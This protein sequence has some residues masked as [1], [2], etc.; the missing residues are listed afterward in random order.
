MRSC[1][2]RDVAPRALK[3]RPRGGAAFCLAL[4]FGLALILA[5][6]TLTFKGPLPSADAVLTTQYLHA[7]DV[8]VGGATYNTINTGAVTGTL[9]ESKASLGVASVDVALADTSG[10]TIF[11]SNPVPAGK[12]WNLSGV[13]TFDTAVKASVSTRL[14]MRAKVYRINVNGGISQLAY[15]QDGTRRDVT[16]SYQVFTWS[17]TMPTGTNINAGERFGVEF[18][19]YPNSVATGQFAYLGFD[20]ST[21]RSDVGAQVTESSAPANVRQAHVRVGKDTPLSAM[22]WYGA[23][24][25]TGIIYQS[26]NFRIR[27]Q[28]YNDGTTSSSW[29][30]RLDWSSTSGSGYA[31]VPLTSG[32]TPFFISNTTQFAN[33]DP[34]S[35]VDFALGVGAGTAQAGV[36][37]DT[38]NP[39]ASA[40]TLNTGSYTEIEFSVQ[41]NTNAGVGYIYYF[42]LS[43][44]GTPLDA[45]DI[46][47]GVVKISSPPPPSPTP[48]NPAHNSSQPYSAETAACAACH[49]PHTST[50][51]TSL[52]KTWPEEAICFTCHD[53]SGGPNIQAQFNKPYKMPLAATTGIHSL[54]EWRT[55]SP[56]SF[57]GSN[58]H[59][60]CVDC[61][62]P[63]YAAAGNHVLGQNYATG[64]LQRMWG[65]TVNNINPWASPTYDTTNSVTYQYQICFKCHTTWAYGSNPPNTPSGGFPETDISKEFNPL[66]PSYMPVEDIGNNPFRTAGGV[67]Y[68]S[69][70]IGGFTPTS[71]L[72]CSDCHASDNDADPRGPHGSNNPFILRGPWNRQTGQRTDAKVPGINSSGHLCF[73]CHDFQ[74]YTNQN[75]VG[76]PNQTGFSGGGKNMHALMVGAANKSYSNAA[77]VCMDCHVVIPH[78]YYR[79]HLI[80]YTGD[81]APYIN[82]PYSGGLTTIDSWAASGQWN[83]NNCSTAMGNCK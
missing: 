56:S 78:G 8:V 12:I 1:S 17:Y 43:K 44:N 72:V 14:W 50:A 37:Y 61:H 45:Y 46:G 9:V 19:V 63:H 36:A 23:T 70:L 83:Y 39:P 3:V 74:V 77:I 55:K 76:N 66:N 53:G 68:A 4:R 31:A 67:S 20:A 15:S 35:T 79:N 30:P 51:P 7:A 27:F 71:R 82:R 80:G 2:R 49:R 34:I 69:S 25:A 40:I 42:R 58:R 59:V 5:A 21:A 60:E 57:S 10:I 18:Y 65:I 52:E 38:V 75:N 81:P 28:V 29:Q 64:P 48:G 11:A 16:T 62:N 41:A 32:A 47:Y 73:K 33:G 13:W 22:D 26:T 54:S 24:D 6:G